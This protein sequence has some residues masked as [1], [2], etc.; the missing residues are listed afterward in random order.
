[1]KRR[2]AIRII[3]FLCIAVI[4]LGILTWAN[5]NKVM[6]LEQ[7]VNAS[8]QHSFSEL[9]TNMSQLDSALQKSLYATSP[10]VASAMCTE[11]FGKAMMAQMSLG[12]MPFST[13]ELEQT[14]AFIS[15]VGDYAFT[16]SRTVN[17]G[18]GYTD[19][20]RANLKSMSSAAGIFCQNLTELQME[21]AE[22]RLTFEELE[23]VQNRLDEA[24]DGEAPVTL[25]GSMKL[26]EGEFP[27][28][29][30]LIYDGPFSEHLINAEAKLLIGAEEISQEEGRKA[31]A[32][33]LGI[34]EGKVSLSAISEGRL[35]AYY[36]TA[37]T[38]GGETNVEVSISGGKIISATSSRM[39]DESKISD[40]DAVKAATD[41]LERRGY[42]SMKKSY[43]MKD[44]GIM[45]VNFAYEQDGALCYSDLIKVGV[46]M[47]NGSMVFFEAKGYIMNHMEREIPEVMIS[48]EQ[49]R[50]HVS[51]ELEIIGEELVIIPTS[52]NYELLC[53]EF[54]CRT[55]DEQEYIIYVNAVSGKQE[56]ILILLEDENGSLTL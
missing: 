11:V 41:F 22:G 2:R 31:A 32:D 14:A 5:H 37:R 38:N 34:Q 39:V 15:K 54:K 9:A 52:G 18:E 13:V 8:Y 35:P 33:F 4:A 1:M 23:E 6:E 20:E 40:E 44:N 10:S 16:L 30:S 27:E 29:P 53:H 25:G 21:M 3:S 55:E 49:A 51:V 17:K 26:I 50:E 7:H 36:F 47:D 43:H 48:A 46:A 42:K 45:T 24:E 12:M 56:K 28:M 19:E